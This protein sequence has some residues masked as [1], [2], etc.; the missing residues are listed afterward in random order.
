MESASL[1]SRKKTTTS[2]EPSSELEVD[3]KGRVVIHS[4]GE[5][6]RWRH[7]LTVDAPM[8]VTQAKPP[9]GSNG[10]ELYSEG[11]SQLF[12][13]SLFSTPEDSIFN[14]PLSPLYSRLCKSAETWKCVSVYTTPLLDLQQCLIS[15]QLMSSCSM[16]GI[17]CMT[18]V[19]PSYWRR[20]LAI[21]FSHLIHRVN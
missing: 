6:R 19:G 14:S 20:P 2:E 16:Y 3:W 17:G 9:I 1:Q 18:Y 8:L 7:V 5:L 15:L 12:S 4:W 10:H 11:N 13:T 21:G